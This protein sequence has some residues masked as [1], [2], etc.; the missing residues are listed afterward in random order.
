MNELIYYKYNDPEHGWLYGCR[1]IYSPT[2]CLG[3]LVGW[4][5]HHPNATWEDCQYQEISEEEYNAL[6][7]V[8]E[9]G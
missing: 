4:H 7:P 8:H 9:E 1:S 5:G 3:D 2:P 6:P